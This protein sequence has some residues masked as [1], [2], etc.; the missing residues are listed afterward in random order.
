MILT[1]VTAA[2][3]NVL[4]VK[5]CESATQHTHNTGFIWAHG[6]ENHAYQ[7]STYNVWR[8]DRTNERQKAKIKSTSRVRVGPKHTY[9]GEFH[10]A[11]AA[12]ATATTVRF[13]VNYSWMMC[14]AWE[15]MVS[16]THLEE[17]KVLDALPLHSL[18]SILTLSHSLSLHHSVP[19]PVC[20]LHRELRHSKLVA[21]IEYI[22]E[23]AV[24]GRA[25]SSGPRLTE[26]VY[27]NS[28]IKIDAQDENIFSSF[29]NI[30]H[31]TSIYSIDARENS[32]VWKIVFRFWYVA[33]PL[34]RS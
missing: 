33:S 22:V 19:M 28:W 21:W 31:F 13:T 34:N 26:W 27:L 25:H 1:A 6:A 29:R 15:W 23:R 24:L 11:A 20:I 10:K 5:A 8:E 9:E 32:K 30:V 12:T 2:A 17:A 3:K 4:M 14:A 16:G 18:C 7:K